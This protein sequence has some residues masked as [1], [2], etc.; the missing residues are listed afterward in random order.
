[1]FD[2]IVRVKVCRVQVQSQ[3]K[4]DWSTNGWDLKVRRMKKLDNCGDHSLVFMD[5]FWKKMCFEAAA[6]PK[7]ATLGSLTA[8]TYGSRRDFR[9]LFA[10]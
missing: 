9:F 2:D 10:L 4:F 1:M 8:T 3:P 5:T 7:T 6:D